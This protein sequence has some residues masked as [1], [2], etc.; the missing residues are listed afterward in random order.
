MVY[1]YQVAKNRRV[2]I[3]PIVSGLLIAGSLAI[4]ALVHPLGGIIALAISGLISYF[5]VKFYFTS[6]SSVV[7]ITDD[8]LH[9]TTP[10]GSAYWMAW[11]D[12]S[13]AGTFES[14]GK[15]PEL[16][17]YAEKE[18]RLFRI[19]DVYANRSEMIDELATYCGPMLSLTG[20]EPGDLVGQL[21]DRLSH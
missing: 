8:G 7:R 5:L 2:L 16:F 20:A 15:A 4:L 21:R 19:P 10:I 14:P 9:G 18:D 11:E 6:V 3:L 17:L 12:V 1:R 13:M